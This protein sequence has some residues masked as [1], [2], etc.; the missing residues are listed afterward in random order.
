MNVEAKKDEEVDEIPQEKK[1][2]DEKEE[3][4][5]EH[6]NVRKVSVVGEEELELDYNDDV[7]ELDDGMMDEDALLYGDLGFAD[8]EQTNPNGNETTT[9]KV[10]EEECEEG[11][12]L[13]DDLFGMTTASNDDSS[14]KKLLESPDKLSEE[15]AEIDD[16][17]DNAMSIVGLDTESEVTSDQNEATDS[18]R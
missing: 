11:E 4:D 13:D 5:K 1:G 8:D 3:K 16:A 6:E 17:I 15:D 18:N 14:V 7:A 10:A 12:I 9:K 2:D